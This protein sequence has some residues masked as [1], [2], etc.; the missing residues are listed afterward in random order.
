MC[1]FACFSVSA[2]MS[3]WLYLLVYDRY[4]SCLHGCR[5]M[6]VISTYLPINNVWEMYNACIYIIIPVVL[7]SCA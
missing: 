6:S 1:V 5:P 4:V 2:L 7:C 3:V